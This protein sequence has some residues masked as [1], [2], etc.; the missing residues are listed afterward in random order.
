MASLS[1]LLRGFHAASNCAAL[2]YGRNDV[3][4]LADLLRFISTFDQRALQVIKSLH[5]LS[6]GELVSRWLGP[7]PSLPCCMLIGA[8]QAPQDPLATRRAAIPQGS[9]CRLLTPPLCCPP[10]LAPHEPQPWALAKLSKYA[11]RTVEMLHDLTDERV[12][13]EQHGVMHG[14]QDEVVSVGVMPKTA[15]AHSDVRG[16]AVQRQPSRR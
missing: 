10:Q 13:E 6:Y 7:K 4:H 2:G 3:A 1:D 8:L 12:M 16:R 9:S 15:V 11:A 14:A 5:R